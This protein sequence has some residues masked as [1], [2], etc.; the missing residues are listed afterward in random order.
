M[1]RRC[2]NRLYNNDINWERRK[3]HG[4]GIYFEIRRLN[5]PP[6]TIASSRIFQYLYISIPGEIPRFV[7]LKLK[8]KNTHIRRNWYPNLYNPIASIQY[9]CVPIYTYIC[10]TPIP[11][12]R[13][14]Y[15]RCTLAW[16]ITFDSHSRTIEVKIVK[17]KMSSFSTKYSR[18]I[19]I[20]GESREGTLKER[21]DIRR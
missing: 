21:I 2:A 1:S 17:V 4:V 19:F 14:Q 7:C 13:R 8:K 15:G 16:K 10:K 9:T 12:T 11:R 5:G 18:L 3:K 6:P 20:N